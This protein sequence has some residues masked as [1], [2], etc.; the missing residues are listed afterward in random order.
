[1]TSL[2][3]SPYPFWDEGLAGN[4]R[5]PPGL[6]LLASTQLPYGS[7]PS[8]QHSGFPHAVWHRHSTSSGNSPV[9]VNEGNSRNWKC[10]S[11]G[12]GGSLKGAWF[13][14][15]HRAQSEGLVS[16]RPACWPPLGP[17]QASCLVIGPDAH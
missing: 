5:S 10:L 7:Q 13:P 11:P 3:L 8:V 17:I 12:T 4:K 6:P 1:M 2:G 9:F 14:P 16:V 15:A